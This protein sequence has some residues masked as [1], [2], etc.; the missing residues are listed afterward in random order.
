MQP[1]TGSPATQCHGAPIRILDLFAGAGGFTQGF[2]SARKRFRTVRAVESDLAAAAS[3][4][5]TF[6]DEH[7]YAGGIEDWLA[8]E[9]VPDVDVI[10]GGPPCQGFSTLGKQ[11]AEDKRNLLWREYVEVVAKADPQYFVLENVPAFLR[12]PQ[13]E[14]FRQATDKEEALCEYTF[15]PYVLNA[16]DYGAAQTRRRVVVIGHHRDLPD[17]GEPTP[18]HASRHITVAEALCEVTPTVTDAELPDTWTEFA[19][20][21]FPGAFKTAEL[22]LTRHYTET[23]LARFDTIPPE[24]NRFDIPDELLSPCWKKHKSGS[25]DVMGRMWPDKPSVTIRTE[26]FKP[27]KGRYLHPTENRAITHYEAALLQGFPEDHQWVGSKVSIA[28]QVG[29]AV[30]VPLGRAI[31][32]HLAEAVDEQ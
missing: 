25:A 3:Y 2:H 21:S 1:V 6:G 17:P 30:P 31:A 4:A 11:D 14:L 7:I 20:R 29:N 26:F 9:N 8:E 28:R 12:S 24:G 16:A 15:T 22:H 19:G 13:F 18:T 32:R 27:E 10:V 5:H 23:S